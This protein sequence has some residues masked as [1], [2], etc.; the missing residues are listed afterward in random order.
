M[1]VDTKSDVAFRIE[2]IASRDALAASWCDVERPG[3][4]AFFTSWTWIGAWLGTLP[5]DI[6][7]R[8]IRAT[9][10]GETVALAVAV[11]RQTRRHIFVHTRQLHFNSTGDPR[12]DAIAIEHNDFAGE[13]GLL[14]A[15]VAWFRDTDC[16]DELVIPGA[17]PDDV[18]AT[19]GLLLS[20][21]KVPAFARDKLD[22]VVRDGIGAVLSRN[23]R[24][25]ISR[26][27]RD[28][29]RFG[30]LRVE[31]AATPGDAL[32]Y[33]EALK[34]LH[35]RSWTRRGKRHA[36]DSA[37]FETFHRALIS[38]GT[39]QLLRISAGSQV[40]GYLYNLRQGGVVYAY[41]SGFADELAKDRP[42]YAS[43]ALAIEHCAKQGVERYDF[44]AGDNRLKRTFGAS[45]YDLCWSMFSRP[46]PVLRFE[47]ML[48][49]LR[50]AAPF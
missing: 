43:H 15:F 23:A 16:A 4:G 41:Q 7:P 14:P 30:A 8:L 40:I 22:I 34:D 18:P 42:G 17:S 33:F 25:H 50:N 1:P 37:Y 49:A 27:I 9:R 39:G 11:F 5:A 46:T 32:A 26:N 29:S 6:E 48:R 19:P 3:E 12:Y 24:Q 28:L 47:A 35:I 21:R 31:E 2:A 10:E 36:F 13:R 38:S 20:M 45:Q 44:L